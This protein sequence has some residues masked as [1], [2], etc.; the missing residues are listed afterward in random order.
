MTHLRTK[1]LT[2]FNS[3]LN[4]GSQIHK[5]N[6]GSMPSRLWCRVYAKTSVVFG[7]THWGRDKMDASSQTTFS[8]AFS[9]MK[10]VAFW[11]SLK[12][13]RKGP[14]VNNPALVQLMAW[15]RSGAKPLSEPMM[16][17]LPTHICV[18][19][20]QWVK[21]IPPKQP[22]YAHGHWGQPHEATVVKMAPTRPLASRSFCLLAL[23]CDHR[24]P[25][26]LQQSNM[27]AW[28]TL[29]QNDRL[30]PFLVFVQ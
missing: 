17:S 22:A 14:I 15:R 2:P 3:P 5:L 7:L 10:I 25:S 21:F 20:P 9:S 27:R 18:T 29:H 1:F 13:V 4:F 28:Y 11:I 16:I 30:V 26:N 23:L 12:Y 19:R 6:T 24:S 8:R